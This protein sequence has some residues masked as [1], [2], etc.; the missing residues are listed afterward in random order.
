MR[1]RTP[2]SWPD[3]VAATHSRL[4]RVGHVGPVV[5]V[6]TVGQRFAAGDPAQR[7]EIGSITKVLTGLLL[8][9][10]ALD[11][12][13]SL[14]DRVPEF[15]PSG[16]RVAPG[17][18]RIT[19]ESLACHRS[20]LPRLPPGV[21][22]RSFSRRA[23]VDPYADIDGDRLIASLARTRVRGDPGQAGARYSNY[24]M[25]L[26]GFLLGHAAGTGYE[27]ALTSRVLAPLGMAGSD[28]TDTAVHQGRH[29]REP[30]GLWH[31][32]ALAGAGGLRSTAGDLLVLLE[33]VRDG[34]SPL[35]P[36]IVEAVR[37]RGRI[38]RAEVG[39][40]WLILG[41]GDLLM[42]N[43]GTLGAR[44]EIRLE[45]HSGTAVVVLGDGRRGT[46]PA[47]A[48]LLAPTRRLP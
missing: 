20:G 12:V 39:L 22:A 16:T 38:G 31:L 18:E 7:F 41:G 6:S 3:R 21:F 15:L 34:G 29:R 47:A 37:P 4:V 1:A 43:G 48:S 24:G 14:S 27:Q 2:A 5:A 11:G 42:H 13:V 28:F 8:A 35:Q 32:A 26:L 40:G 10:L 44:S 23:M 19:L 17:V 25:G 30:V 9:D 45:R 33:A 36:A 46:G